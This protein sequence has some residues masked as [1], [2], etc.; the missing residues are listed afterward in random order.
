MRVV[1]NPSKRNRNQLASLL[2]NRGQ[3]CTVTYSSRHVETLVCN[4]FLY[5]E[6]IVKLHFIYSATVSRSHLDTD[7][8]SERK[9]ENP[10]PR[11]IVNRLVKLAAMKQGH[12]VMLKRC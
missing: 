1:K 10:V 3:L 11:Y 4:R 9:T 5:Q 2:K 7:V 8:A 6:A 12:R